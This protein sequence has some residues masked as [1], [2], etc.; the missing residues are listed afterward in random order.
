MEAIAQEA[1]ARADGLLNERLEREAAITPETQTR[2]SDVESLSRALSEVAAGSGTQF[3]SLRIWYF[4]TTVEEWTGNGSPPTVV[5]GWLR[6]ASGTENPYV[7][8]P[9]AL[10]V[11]G[12][13]YRFV[14]LRVKR[15]GDAAWDG[16]LQ[17]IT[18]ADQAWD[19]DKRAAI[20]EPRWDDNGVG[21]VDVADIAWWPG[22]VDAIRLQFGA[23]QT[24]SSYFATDWV[25]IGR[26][27]PGAGVA[28]V[29]EEARARVAADVAE[30]SKRETLA[31]QLR[32][33]YEGSDLSQCRAACLLLS[34]MRGSRPMR[35]TP[36]PSRVIQARM[37]TGDG[38]VATEASVT[39][40]RQARADGDSANAEAIERVSARMPAGDGEV[41]SPKHWMP[42]R[43]AWKKRRRASGQSATERRRWKHR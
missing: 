11:D 32:G 26:P 30:A 15:V 8:S 17:W 43:P 1:Q 19:V 23:T 39:E 35:P 31:V 10:G 24:V 33:D 5:D 6:P 13:A 28:L 25:A 36:A 7:Q 14:K 37:P 27:T 18:L 2:Q 34:A 42:S 41:A 29:E 4:D 38:T 40:E 3:D 22:E 9:A 16:F 12:S 20:P 21:T